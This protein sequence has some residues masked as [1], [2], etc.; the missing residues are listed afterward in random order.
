ML[1]DGV[2]ITASL[3][4]K[5]SCHS[6]HSYRIFILQKKEK[7]TVKVTPTWITSPEAPSRATDE[8]YTTVLT[9]DTSVSQNQCP[10]FVRLLFLEFRLYPFQ[11]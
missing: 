6:I 9:S 7:K 11:F 10:L 4:G 5:N 2:F 1:H 8:Y 3:S